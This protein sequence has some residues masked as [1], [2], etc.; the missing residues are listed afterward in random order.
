MF[1]KNYKIDPKSIET[2]PLFT[3]LNPVTMISSVKQL[4]SAVIRLLGHNHPALV[5]QNS[6]QVL[7]FDIEW[8]A[9]FEPEIYNR[10]ALLQFYVPG[11]AVIVRLN[12]LIDEAGGF[13]KFVFPKLLRDIL[14]NP[15]LLKVGLGIHN[16]AERLYHD[17]GIECQ[18]LADIA[19]LPIHKQCQPKGLAGLAAIFMGIKIDK[20]LALSN[21]ESARLSAEQIRYAAADAF[22]S[23]ELY[24]TLY[25]KSMYAQ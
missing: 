10:T 6:S 16:D 17:F 13:E 3:Y 8:K 15:Y 19:D 12:K 14:E 21:W 4:N 22:L 20:K 18:G 2:L 23:R 25:S 24:L 5:T 11:V 7:G 9:M 1:D